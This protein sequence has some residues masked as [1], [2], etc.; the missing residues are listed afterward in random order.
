MKK[1]IVPALL[2]GVIIGL[3]LGGNGRE[4]VAQFTSP[5]DS[6]GVMF[7]ANHHQEFRFTLQPGQTR[8]ID[9]PKTDALIRFS[10][11]AT[12]NSFHGYISSD[13]VVD[14]LTGNIVVSTL[15]GGGSG[16]GSTNM[17]LFLENG[18]LSVQNVGPDAN[19]GCVSLWY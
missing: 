1:T 12:R 3:L 5:P 18:R 11:T 14:P 17:L 7:L 8:P 2:L 15:S 6:H 16:M 19:S 13:V 4:A 9:L 10:I